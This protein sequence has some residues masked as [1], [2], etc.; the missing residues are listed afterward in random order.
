MSNLNY[1]DSPFITSDNPVLYRLP[2]T[3]WFTLIDKSNPPVFYL[4]LHP[5]L[6]L[7]LQNFK[8]ESLEDKKPGKIISGTL[9]YLDRDVIIAMNARIYDQ[10]S[11]IIMNAS[12][13]DYYQEI[14]QKSKNMKEKDKLIQDNSK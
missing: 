5:N 2:E 14:V 10:S 7:L 9:D 6:A 13:P 12:N 8:V 11:L 3:S 1:T 4:A